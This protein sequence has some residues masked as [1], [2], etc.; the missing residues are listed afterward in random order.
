[1]T[2]FGIQAAKAGAD[3]IVQNSAGF[4]LKRAASENRL[5]IAI[6]G[7][8]REAYVQKKLEGRFKDANVQWESY[9][10]TADG[11]RAVDPDTGEA[12]RI[13]HAVIQ[14]G[15]ALHLVETTSRTA[16]KTEQVA[17]EL[18]IRDAGPVYIRDRKTGKL[19]DVSNVPTRESRRK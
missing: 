16:K 6:D 18:R 4:S 3:G 14:D 7:A 15:K 17:K 11:R 8:R 5:Q 9:L 10:R 19:I 12:R 1:M 2:A 13:D